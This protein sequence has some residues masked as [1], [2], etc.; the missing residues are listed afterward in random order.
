[1]SDFD[2]AARAALEFAGVSLGEGDL[3]VLRVV[4]QM[5]EPGTRLLDAADLSELPL[6]GDLD[7]GRPPAQATPTADR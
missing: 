7:P 4:A 6:E 3:D 1:M 2:D 5:A